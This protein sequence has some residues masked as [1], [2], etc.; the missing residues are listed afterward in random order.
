MFLIY[1]H[2]LNDVIDDIVEAFSFSMVT[3]SGNRRLCTNGAL[4]FFSRQVLTHFNIIS[5]K[6]SCIKSSFSA[7]LFASNW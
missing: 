7:S 6:I 1:L 5:L 2:C 4:D 3:K